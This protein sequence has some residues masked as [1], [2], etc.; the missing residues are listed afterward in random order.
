MKLL[1]DENLS[2]LLVGKL[3]ALGFD[4]VHVRD[5]CKGCSDLKIAE[6]ALRDGRTIVTQD[7]G[8]GLLFHNKGLSVILVRMK[9]QKLDKITWLIKNIEKLKGDLTNSLV[10]ITEEKIRVKKIND[11]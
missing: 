7:K 9:S 6:I 11:K 2:P 10:V 1:I 5:I 8:F 4:T 3:S